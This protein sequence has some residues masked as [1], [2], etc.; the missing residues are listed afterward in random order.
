MKTIITRVG[1]ATKVV[2]TGDPYQIDN[3]YVDATSNGLTTVV[4]KFKG[5]ADRR[6]RDAVEG[7]ALAARRAGVE[8]A[9]ES[10]NANRGAH[11]R[12]RTIA[13]NGADA[14]ASID[15]IARDF[16]H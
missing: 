11:Q 15:A 10:L 2:L 4:E 9:V 14:L 1:E 8:R 12:G 6:P 7:R 3:P 13:G 5:E 16:V